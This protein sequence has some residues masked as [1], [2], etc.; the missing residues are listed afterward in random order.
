M[1][2][3]R[4]R[5]ERAWLAGRLATGRQSGSRLAPRA[6]LAFCRLAFGRL[7]F[8]RLARTLTRKCC[9]RSETPFSVTTTSG[10]TARISWH[11]AVTQSS[12]CLSSASH[13]DSSVSSTDVAD[14]PFLYSSVQSRRRTRG[15]SMRRRILGWVMS[16]LIITPLST[17][18]CSMSPPGSF[19]TFAYLLMSISIRP[20]ESE[21]TVSTASRASST[22]W[23][24]KREMNLVPMLERTRLHSSARFFRSIGKAIPRRTTSASSSARR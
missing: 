9:A 19:S 15:R 17:R 14:S 12:S 11:T 6:P 13:C 24:E 3:P 23:S 5:Q 1:C 7:A 10:L 18:E 20:C 4:A 21:Y 22:I 2:T 16:L 8:G